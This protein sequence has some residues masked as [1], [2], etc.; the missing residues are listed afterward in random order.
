MPYIEECKRP[1]Y[2]AAL[3]NMP[4][5]LCKGDLEYCIFKLMKIFMATR[6]PRYT[7]LHDCAYAAQHCG[8]EFRRRYL[9]NREDK[10]IEQ[11]GDVVSW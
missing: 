1:R 9:D 5:I 3:N 6:T 10:A 8:D 4:N 7:N 2:D 11:N